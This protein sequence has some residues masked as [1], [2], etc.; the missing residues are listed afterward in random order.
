VNAG[1]T[2][3]VTVNSMIGYLAGTAKVI[4]ST[5]LVLCNGVGYRVN[6]PSNLV[7]GAPVSLHVTTVVREDAITLYG[8]LTN[9]EQDLFDAL[10]SV[11]G[12][13]PTSALALLRDLGFNE[14]IRAVNLKDYRM[15]TKARG[16][17]AKVAERIVS[18]V[19]LP[20]G[21]ADIPAFDAPA[22]LDAIT[23]LET[24]GFERGQA[25]IAVASARELG[26]SETST[27]VKDALASLREG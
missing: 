3:H 24:L 11:S 25:R 27:I 20:I 26:A 12:V 2:I 17:G 6:T 7:D 19:K 21:F 9:V 16:V 23:V 14:I 10:R 8:F 22:D 5:V 1:I 18:M 4:Q 13:G 15:L